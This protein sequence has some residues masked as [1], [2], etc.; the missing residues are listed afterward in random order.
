MAKYMEQEEVS[1]NATI[2]GWQGFLLGLTVMPEASLSESGKARAFREQ[3]PLI[4]GKL[5]RALMDL[6]EWQDICQYHTDSSRWPAGGPWAP[7]LV[8]Y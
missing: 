6:P 1:T 8:L 3:S 5:S 2:S 4:F 7:V